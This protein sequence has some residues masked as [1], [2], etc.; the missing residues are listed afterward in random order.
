VSIVLLEAISSLHNL[1]IM[2]AVSLCGGQ[3]AGITPLG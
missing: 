1:L 3:I 2:R